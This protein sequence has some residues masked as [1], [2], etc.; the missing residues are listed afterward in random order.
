MIHWPFLHHGSHYPISGAKTAEKKMETN[1][2]TVSRSWW[3]LI[4]ESSSWFLGVFH[5]TASSKVSTTKALFFRTSSTKVHTV[6]SHIHLSGPVIEIPKNLPRYFFKWK[7]PVEPSFPAHR[8]HR[9]RDGTLSK[10][11]GSGHL[12]APETVTVS[13]WK[14]CTA[15]CETHWRVP[16]VSDWQAPLHVTQ[17]SYT[18]CKLPGVNKKSQRFDPVYGGNQWCLMMFDCVECFLWHPLTKSII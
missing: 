18:F 6:H 13:Q 15:C 14:R 7:N 11:H 1:S 2:R 3:S 4:F 10:P 17:G 9:G 12:F 5:Q 16:W 8:V